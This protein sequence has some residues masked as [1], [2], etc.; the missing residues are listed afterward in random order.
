M[1]W[2]NGYLF[3][4]ALAFVMLFLAQD[5]MA[6]C[7]NP[8]PPDSICAS[9]CPIRLDAVHYIDADH[10]AA[11][12]FCRGINISDDAGLSWTRRTVP[13]PYRSFRDVFFNNP[14]EGWIVGEVGEILYTNDG[15]LNWVLQEQGATKWWACLSVDENGDL[16]HVGGGD[17]AYALSDN[18]GSG[19]YGVETNSEA[20][21]QSIRS[22]EANN[23]WT[24][25]DAG[26]ILYT[27]DRGESWTEQFSSNDGF[28]DLWVTDVSGVMGIAVGENGQIVHSTDGTTWTPRTS[29]TS[30]TL[31]A[32]FG[33]TSL[34]LFCATGENGTVLISNDGITW[35]T[36]AGL[37]ISG[38]VND[39]FVGDQHIWFC[40]SD[41]MLYHSDDGGEN[42][43]SQT[44]QSGANFTTLWFEY[45]D[46]F[47]WGNGWICGD[48]GVGYLYNEALG[49][50]EFWLPIFFGTG[51]NRNLNEVQFRG[52]YRGWLAGD[53]G[54][55]LRTTNG[56]E[57][58]QPLSVRTGEDLHSI[59]FSGNNDGWICGDGG[60]VHVTENSGRHIWIKPF[61]WEDEDNQ[62]TS[63]FY[64]ISFLT[65]EVGYA[66][67][68]YVGDVEKSGYI[69]KT[70]N[71]GDGDWTWETMF[72]DDDNDLLD[73]SFVSED[74]GWVVGGAESSPY[75]YVDGVIWHTENGG[76]TWEEQSYPGFVK[77]FRAVD[78]VS[79][80]H[81][82]AVG[83][84]AT[85][86][87]TTDGG[88]SWHRQENFC[89]DPHCEVPADFPDT[90]FFNVDFVDENNGIVTGWHEAPGDD[91]TGFMGIW[92]TTDGGRTWVRDGVV[93]V[94]LE[95]LG[96]NIPKA[97]INLQSYPNPFNPKTTIR[98]V[99]PV[100]S[101]V[102]VK[103]YN[104]TGQLVKTL[105]TGPREPGAYA[106]PWDG[107]TENGTTVP[108]GTYFVRYNA[109]GQSVSHQITLLK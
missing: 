27:D 102:S 93:S 62:E 94:P 37:S 25:T 38:N 55:Y 66:C 68:G 104:T 32:V 44:I 71:G 43:S 105:A 9:Y 63:D 17:G 42:W 75:T 12:D 89:E 29:N 74:E 14:Q 50:G 45:T 54:L 22:L 103:V 47:G 98:F 96:V 64:G 90:T 79:A 67:T 72:Y 41:G 108:S 35:N 86:M 109:A 49:L 70:T 3:V 4:V 58:W 53:G 87:N 23:A 84:N 83:T 82:W 51:F 97:E 95:L 18:G 30:E 26:Q 8:D 36:P 33:N 85:I 76:E 31:H 99:V 28:T 60:Q 61:P 19:W 81:G 59:G 107:R 46:D 24:V 106:V 78:F 91:G 21:F 7:S 15:G 40:T 80:T 10:M 69:L 1:M 34:D 101:E 65:D 52:T 100:A 39:V 6:Q 11:V 56:G 20:S 2:K 88:A 13:A 92:R 48:N 73:C 57:S 77:A 16:F 5:V